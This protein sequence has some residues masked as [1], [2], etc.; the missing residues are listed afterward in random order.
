MTNEEA[1]KILLDFD[2]NPCGYCHQG[3]DEIE[4]AF[5][6]AAK[7]LYKQIPKKIN[8]I[9]EVLN[10]VWCPNC[11]YCLGNIEVRRRYKTEYKCCPNCGQALDWED[12]K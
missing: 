2:E 1:I 3:G 4:T 12:E 7:A 5:E 10:A 11:H 6:M 8:I 9:K